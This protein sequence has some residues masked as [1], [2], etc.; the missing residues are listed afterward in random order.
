[1]ATA[2]DANDAENQK[3]PGL[4]VLSV[5]CGNA[6]SFRKPALPGREL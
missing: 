4:C 6:T 2:E 1:M 3:I 5:L